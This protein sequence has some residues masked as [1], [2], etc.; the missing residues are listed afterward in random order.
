MNDDNIKQK[1]VHVNDNFKTLV[2][3][4]TIMNHDWKP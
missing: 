3:Y 4:T 2:D 1:L